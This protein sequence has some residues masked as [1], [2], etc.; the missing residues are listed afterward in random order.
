MEQAGREPWGAVLRREAGAVAMV[1]M[2]LAGLG[3]SIY[4]TIIHYAKI[5]PACVTNSIINCAAVTS[6][7]YSVV[8][9]TSVPI[10][11]PGMLWFVLSGG[12][13]GVALVSAWRG[14]PEPPRLRAT[15]ALWGALG[16]VFV[17]YLVYAE[18]VRLQRI[19][20]WCTVVHVLTLATFLVA[21]ARLQSAWV[22]PAQARDRSGGQSTRVEHAS[23]H[24]SARSRAAQP[25]VPRRTAQRA[26]AR[27]R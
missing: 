17:L 9:G 5:P 11:I 27:R 26:R 19:C 24:P 14:T 25:A 21:L 10:T 2:A 20:E 1:L 4:L 15:H 16:L 6:S 18:I 23:A 22:A 13:A 3:I 7:V 8:P 12:L